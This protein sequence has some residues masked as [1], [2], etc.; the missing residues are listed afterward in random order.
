MSIASN[1]ST[2]YF[3]DC[4]TFPTPT[5]LCLR[6]SRVS[7]IENGRNYRPILLSSLLYRISGKGSIELVYNLLSY[8]R[9]QMTVRPQSDLSVVHVSTGGARRLTDSLRRNFPERQ[10]WSLLWTRQIQRNKGSAGMAKVPPQAEDVHIAIRLWE[11]SEN[12][13]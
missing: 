2:A 7:E 5:R 12:L 1:I 4:N 3:S 8:P 6:Q 13:I 11:V 9:R 10:S